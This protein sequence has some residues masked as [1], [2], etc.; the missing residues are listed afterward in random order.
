MYFW[1]MMDLIIWTA[2]DEDYAQIS[3]QWP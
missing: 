3:D 1:L 2:M